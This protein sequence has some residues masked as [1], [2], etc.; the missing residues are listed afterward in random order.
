MFRVYSRDYETIIEGRFDTLKE[1]QK[2]AKK[3][4]KKYTICVVIE[5]N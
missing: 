2:C 1:A 4:G 5:E 3:L